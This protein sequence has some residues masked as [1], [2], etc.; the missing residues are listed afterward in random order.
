MTR[1][2]ATLGVVV[3]AA[4]LVVPTTSAQEAPVGTSL[5][6]LDRTVQSVDGSSSTV[7]A[8]RGSRATVLVFWSNQCPWVDRYEERVLATAARYRDQGVN[9]IL[10]NPNDAGAFPQETAAEGLARAQSGGYAPVPYIVDAGSR[11]ATALGASRTPH[12][13]IFDGNNA[14]VYVGGIDDSPGDPANVQKNYLNDALDALL[15]G[16]GVGVA[17][18]RAFGCTIKFQQ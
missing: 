2:L 10:V 15:A 7:G 18:T 5:P 11:L 17:Q 16:R 4:M 14:L 9:V 8:L 1:F 3:L 12:V 13:Y 6:L